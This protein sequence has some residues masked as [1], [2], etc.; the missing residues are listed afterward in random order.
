[1]HMPLG[2]Q[3]LRQKY[4]AILIKF[5]AGKIAFSVYQKVHLLHDEEAINL[6]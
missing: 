2:A 6:F 4:D 5:K 1:M 3:I